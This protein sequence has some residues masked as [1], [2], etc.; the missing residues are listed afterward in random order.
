ML[1]YMAVAQFNSEENKDNILKVPVLTNSVK[2]QQKLVDLINQ[3][4]Q[5]QKQKGRIIPLH[6]RKQQA[7]QL[8]NQKENSNQR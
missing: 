1:K 7:I 4:Q 3:L 2:V 6:V 8:I 5:K